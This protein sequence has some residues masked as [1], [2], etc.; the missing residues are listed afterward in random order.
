MTP[1]ELRAIRLGLGLSQ[2]AMACELGLG[3][4]GG[5]TVR[6]YESGAIEPSGPVLRLYAEF[7]DGKLVVKGDA[8]LAQTVEQRP[9]K[10]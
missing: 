2:A 4:N 3:A 5:R 10:P 1:T 7:R 9:C 6:R 8:G